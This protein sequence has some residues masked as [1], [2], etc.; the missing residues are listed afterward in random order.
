MLLSRPNSPDW[1]ERPSIDKCYE[2]RGDGDFCVVVVVNDDDDDDFIEYIEFD[3][4]L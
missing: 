2:E 4:S 3:T 1:R